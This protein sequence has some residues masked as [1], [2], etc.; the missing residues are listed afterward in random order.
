MG[1]RVNCEGKGHSGKLGVRDGGIGF[2][3]DLR[4]LDM[5]E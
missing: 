2:V 5:T 4:T 1:R 3:Y